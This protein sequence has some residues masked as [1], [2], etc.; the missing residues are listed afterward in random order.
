MYV[1]VCVIMCMTLCVIK[2]IIM[3]MHMYSA[4]VHNI[5]I[6]Y[7]I[8]CVHVSMCAAIVHVAVSVHC[9]LAGKQVSRI[10]RTQLSNFEMY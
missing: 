2:L 7:I 8:M 9:D 3:Y 4:C 6:W 1:C 5:F 10:L